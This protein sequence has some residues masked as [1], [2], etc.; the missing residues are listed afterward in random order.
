MIGHF[1]TWVVSEDRTELIGPCGCR[2]ANSITGI[3]A[4][5]KHT[6][7]ASESEKP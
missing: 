4:A 6:C 3:L 2:V 7:P 1:E 5:R